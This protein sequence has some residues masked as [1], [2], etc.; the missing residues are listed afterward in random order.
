MV[1][2]VMENNTQSIDLDTNK[3][4]P[5]IIVIKTEGFHRTLIEWLPFTYAVMNAIIRLVNNK[6]AYL[7]LCLVFLIAAGLVGLSRS[8]LNSDSFILLYT[9]ASLLCWILCLLT[10]DGWIY[11]IDKYIYSLMYIG[12]AVILLDQKENIFKY[13][14]LYFAVAGYIVYKLLLRHIPIREFMLDGSTYNF[15]SVICLFYL[16]LTGIMQ[17]KNGE[18]LSYVE[19]IL[20]TVITLIA[21]GRGG[22]VSAI[23]LLTGTAILKF[24]QNRG[25]WYNWLFMIA[26]AIA[27]FVYGYKV[28]AY[29]SANYFGKF[30][31]YGFDNNGRTEIWTGFLKNNL[32]SIIT[33]LFGSN[34]LRVMLSGNLHNSLLQLYASFGLIFLVINLCLIIQSTIFFLK[35]KEY[36]LVLVFLV[37]FVR[38]LTDMVLF[39]GYCEI[40]YYYYIFKYFRDS[41]MKIQEQII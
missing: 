36:W 24:M 7:S 12:I 28:F 40:I 38:S 32:E 3:R 23:V 25:K 34:P 37:V 21:Y 1:N 19:V 4:L 22:I 29:L 13:K 9:G 33:F 5:G 6:S 16:S 14:V 15:I 35:Q 10:N 11:A 27:L 26:F 31:A 8:I 39:R 20:Y 17:C 30:L 18:P 2:K 41:R